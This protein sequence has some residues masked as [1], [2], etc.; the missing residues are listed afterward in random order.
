MKLKFTSSIFALLLYV[1]AA[2]QISFSTT[3]MPT[4]GFSNR[5]GRDSLHN[6]QVN[7]GSA[8]TNQAYNFNYL[9][10]QRYDTT[11]YSTPTAGQ[12]TNFPNA[13][14]AAT[15]DF[16]NYVLFKNAA[17]KLDVEGLQGVIL[18]QSSVAKFNPVEDL[19]HFPTQY[20]NNYSGTWGFKAQIDGS[21]INALLDS[22][23]LDFVDYY[24]DTIDGWGKVTTPIGTYKCLRDARRDSSHTKITYKTIFGSYSTFQDYSSVSLGF[25]YLTK[26]AKGA[27]VSFEYDS[28][29][30]LKAARYSFI[31]PNPPIASFTYAGAGVGVI[32]FTDASDNYPTS[33]LWNFGDG[34]T[35]TQQNPQHTYTHNGVYYVCLTA[36][37]AGGSNTFC[38]SV[39]ITGINTAPNA[40]NDSL[41]VLQPN[42]GIINATA[43]DNDPDNDQICITAVY[44]S[45]YF[46]VLNCDSVLF[47]P[48][49]TFTG[50]DSCHYIICDNGSPVKCDT[51]TIV[52]HVLPHTSSNLPPTAIND[53]A[54]A[55]Q[56]ASDT[57]NATA[58]DY[59]VNG[60]TICITL[61]YGN[62]D[63]SVLDCNN[64]AFHPPS[65]FSGNDT[66]WYVICDN[67]SPI[68]CDTAMIVVNVAPIIIPNHPPNA[69][70]DTASTVQPASASIN[71]T[72]NDSDPDGNTI[73]VTTVYGSAQFSV[74]DCNHVSF[75]P[76]TCFHGN[77]T[78]YYILC[79]NGNPVKC[80]TAM[81]TVQVQFN[82]AVLPTASFN[83]LTPVCQGIIAVNTSTNYEN[84][85]WNVNR[86]FNSG[87]YPDT[88]FTSDTIQYA[89]TA[90]ETF[91]ICLVTTNQCG[92]S[93]Q[94]CDTAN[95]ICE[96]IN[97][98]Q[99]S[100]INLY[101]N[102]T[103]NVL[104]IDM[105]NNRD[106]ITNNYTGIEIYNAI[107]EVIKTK[108]RGQQ[109]RIE[110]IAVGD[111]PEG[112]YMASI[113]DSKGARRTLGRF[114]V[115]K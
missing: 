10:A 38:D 78:C 47:Q 99:L 103:N 27:Q 62:L 55:Q 115:N 2:A 3:D 52:V 43:N 59:D 108:A 26:E 18:G 20:G 63:F 40:N 50:Y 44:G 23:Y 53:V 92:T 8:G 14:L 107:G 7:Y 1:T 54:N 30:R 109:M 113:I 71:V 60:D 45:T 80:D 84:S 66:C 61:V 13:N 9:S 86:L 81:L 5:V 4:S 89:Q 34:S 112:I 32:N 110:N 39:H 94:F 46:S 25:S 17:A 48:L 37:N 72:A 111:L 101:P 88:T 12:L 33:W 56:P 87:P 85:I 51:A 96:G 64:I 29:G 42:S 76:D 79:D 75:H 97:E 36:T 104:T 24:K 114:A 21:S 77:D 35:S 57:I 95:A 6:G 82:Q 69:V 67:G 58:N 49:S 31:L 73:C 70:N 19:F 41:T 93:H 74:A 105:R 102:P 98:V 15:T 106:E 22:V 100:N 65:S 28:L 16:V 90:N 83:V 68:M 11:R 91:E